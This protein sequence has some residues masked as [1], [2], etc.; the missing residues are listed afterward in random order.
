MST[1][2]CSHARASL[3]EGTVD[4][5]RCAGHV[6]VGTPECFHS[7]TGQVLDGPPVLPIATYR[8]K[9]KATPSSSLLPRRASPRLPAESRFLQACRR[10]RTDVTRFR[11]MRQAGRYMPEYRALRQ[12]HS[13][14]DLCHSPELAAE[15]TLQA[16]RAP[17]RWIA[18]ILFADIL[19]PFEPL[20]LGLAFQAGEGP[21][22]AVRSGRPRRWPRCPVIEPAEN[23]G[24]VLDAVRLAVRALPPTFPSSVSPALPSR[25]RAT[26]LKAVPR[27]AFAVTKQFMYAESVAW[28][29][30]MSHF[31]ELVGPY[32]AAQAAAGARAL[33]LFDSWSDAS[34]PRTTAIHVPAVQPAGP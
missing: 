10:E 1:N 17:R 21:H 18:A 32:L 16:H 2:R 23:L 12:K 28:H 22:I 19:L 14:L 13:I 11:F 31:A 29:A 8:V 30:L 33:Q 15:V 5:A 20:G 24:Y 6:P 25:S 26:L 3:S 27:A 7:R 4:P 9:S 34:L